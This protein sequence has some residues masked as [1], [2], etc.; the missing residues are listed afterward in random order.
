MPPSFSLGVVSAQNH[1]AARNRLANIVSIKAYIGFMRIA[2]EK[3]RR[4]DVT[5]N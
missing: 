3:R 1:C 5:G 4:A 2:E